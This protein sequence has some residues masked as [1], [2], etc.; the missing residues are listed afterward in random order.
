MIGGDHRQ[1]LP[2][3][4]KIYK[5]MSGLPSGQSNQGLITD[6]KVVVT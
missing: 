5:E 6:N 1:S 4:T 2:S 3:T